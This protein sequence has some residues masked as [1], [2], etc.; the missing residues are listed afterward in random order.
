MGS[1]RWEWIVPADLWEIAQPVLPLPMVRLE[2][3]QA[4]N[5]DDEDVFAAVIYVLVS[6]C[7]WR[8]LPSCF[9][10]S[11]ST[12]HRRFLIWSRAGVWEEL[13]AAATVAPARATRDVLGF[14]RVVVEAARR[15]A[16]GTKSQ[17]ARAPWSGAVQIASCDS[18]PM[19]GACPS[20]SVSR[21]DRHDQS[22]AAPLADSNWSICQRT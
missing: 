3:G 13:L 5:A 17:Q 18:C 19:D 6:D 2:N 4:Q 16:E 11:K 7:A 10:I 8:S 14:T 9:G 12:V 15:R 20:W 22:F 21:P 1:N